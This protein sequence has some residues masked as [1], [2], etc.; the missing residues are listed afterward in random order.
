MDR[1]I[2]VLFKEKKNVVGVPLVMQ[3]VLKWQFQ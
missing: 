3:F 2:P 1:K